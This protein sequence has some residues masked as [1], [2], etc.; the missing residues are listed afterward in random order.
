[1][2]YSL[3]VGVH[4][5]SE[6]DLFVN[7]RRPDAPLT[8]RRAAQQASHIP[9]MYVRVLLFLHCIRFL[10]THTHTHTHTHSLSLSLQ[11]V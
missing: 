3:L 1:M 4:D 2:D 11:R 10:Y 6:S 5:L 7:P 9:S 8:P